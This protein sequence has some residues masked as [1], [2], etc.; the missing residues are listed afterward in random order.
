MLYKKES[1]PGRCCSHYLIHQL[2]NVLR[3]LRSRRSRAMHK[4][5]SRAFPLFSSIRYEQTYHLELNVYDK[6][7]TLL[8]NATTLDVVV[9]EGGL[10]TS[11]KKMQSIAGTVFKEQILL[12]FNNE[13]VKKSLLE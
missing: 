11:I 5:E 10:A 7:G 4:W 13:A 9:N 3:K 2:K 8:A 6:N 12:L 1:T